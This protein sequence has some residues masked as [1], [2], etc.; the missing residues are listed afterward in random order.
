[1]NHRDVLSSALATALALGLA[2][3]ASAQ[4]KPKEKC[5]GISKAGTNDCGNRAGTHTCAGQSKSDFHHGD[6]RYV[7]KGTCRE[8]KGL[9]EEEAKEKDKEKDKAQRPA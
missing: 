8:L 9:S 4:A 2:G 5:Y 3:Q 1:M 6:W 7:P